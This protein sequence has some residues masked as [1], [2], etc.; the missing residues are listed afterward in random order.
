[1]GTIEPAA[2]LQWGGSGL[3]AMGGMGDGGIKGRWAQT[4]CSSP[5]S[6]L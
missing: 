3:S 1:M 4:L 5:L 6:D 2:G